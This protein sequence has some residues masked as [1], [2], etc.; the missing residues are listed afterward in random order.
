MTGLN[1]QSFAPSA[2]R[3]RSA[4]RFTLVE[5]LAAMAVLVI[6]MG[7]LFQFL[8]SAQTTWSLTDTN[9][10]IYESAHIVFE[11]IS[12]DLQSAI[13]SDM[14][15]AEIPFYF[16]NQTLGATYQN[17][18]LC[19]VAAVEPSLT[20]GAETRLCEIGYECFTGTPTTDPQRTAQYCFG[21]SRTCDSSATDW[22]FYGSY[23]AN[24]YSNPNNGAE[25]VVSG[26][27]S[28]EFRCYHPTTTMTGGN[29][30]NELPRAVQVT[31]TLFDPKLRTNWDNLAASVQARSRRTFTKMIFLTGG[32]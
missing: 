14:S 16:G 12:K 30:Y 18:Y 3:R 19:F 9:A 7:F 5:L 32:S 17:V 28:V 2:S 24:W 8:G 31:I 21:R 29:S 23:P 1:P 4:A 22:N 25:K 6:L 10:R 20:T 27:E 13:A 11:V 15:D 26:V